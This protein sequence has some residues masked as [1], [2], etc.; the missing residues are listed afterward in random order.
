MRHDQA[1]EKVDVPEPS[2]K[3]EQY[4]QRYLALPRVILLLPIKIRFLLPVEETHVGFSF[5]IYKIKING[6]NHQPFAAVISAI[7]FCIR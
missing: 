5:W 2:H 1:C 3:H 4:E 7:T 6:L